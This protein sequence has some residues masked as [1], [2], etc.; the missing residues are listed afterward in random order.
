M[1]TSRSMGFSR[2]KPEFASQKDMEAETVTT[3]SKSTVIQLR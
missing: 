2:W 3:L 1:K